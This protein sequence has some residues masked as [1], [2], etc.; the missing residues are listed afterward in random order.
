VSPNGDGQFQ[1]I[2]TRILD[3]TYAKVIDINPAD[4]TDSA[5]RTIKARLFSVCEDGD[6]KSVWL[7]SSET[8]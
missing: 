1:R 6:V 4:I 7:L 8:F 2:A 5:A 3:G